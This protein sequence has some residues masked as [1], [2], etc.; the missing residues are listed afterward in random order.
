[1]TE[2]AR[3][4]WLTWLPPGHPEPPLITR[5]ELLATLARRGTPVNERTLQSWERAGALPAPLR[6]RHHG[7]PRALYPAWYAEVVAAMPRPRAGRGSLADLRPRLRAQFEQA[8]QRASRGD[9]ARRS[10]PLLPA[11]V[12]TAL[13]ELMADLNARGAGVAAAELRLLRPGEEPLRY[14]LPARAADPNDRH[15]A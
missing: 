4:T 10:H 6:R 2:G 9:A 3:E 5:A 12:I 8:A 1:M 7:A 14:M 13:Q 15:G 11:H